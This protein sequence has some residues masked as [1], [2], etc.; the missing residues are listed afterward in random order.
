MKLISLFIVA[1]LLAACADTSRVIFVTTSSIGINVDNKPPTVSIAYDRT[2]GYIGPRYDNGAVPPVVASIETDGGI[3]NPRIRQIYAT[4]AAAVK[5][6]GTPHA[7]DGPQGL[8][9]S[10]DSKR[11]VFFGTTTTL[12]IKAGFSGEGYPDSFVF[13]YK[14]KEFSYIPLGTAIVEGQPTDT[15]PSVLGTI[16]TTT[17]VQTRTGTSLKTLQFFA[18]GQAAETLA[19]NPLVSAVFRN[20]AQDALTASLTEAQV[21]QAMAAAGVQRGAQAER[22]NKILAFVAPGGVVDPTRLGTVVDK[23]NAT[24]RGAFP[25]S[26]KN[27]TTAGQIGSALQNDIPGASQLAAAVDAVS[28]QH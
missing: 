17:N 20:K 1:M 24:T 6:V 15:Y 21:N 13:G 28:A 23:A 2:E 7:P 22:I 25:D 11:M 3:F 10:K 5:A 19:L 27:L 18:T 26:F 4:G 12:G 14:R 16:D 8:L 9:G